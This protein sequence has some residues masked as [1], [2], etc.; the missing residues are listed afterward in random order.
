[1]RRTPMTRAKRT[2]MM[3]FC[4]ILIQTV[5]GDRERRVGGTW[6]VPGGCH[7]WGAHLVTAFVAAYILCR[8]HVSSYVSRMHGRVHV[9]RL[10]HAKSSLVA[11]PSQVT[12]GGRCIYL[13]RAIHQKIRI[14]PVCVRMCCFTPLVRALP[15]RYLRP[16]SHE[17]G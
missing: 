4:D 6:S 1:M 2:V 8:H 11:D 3:D 7:S 12:V 15:L 10:L 14:T 16:E 5:E 17:R 13:G 9:H